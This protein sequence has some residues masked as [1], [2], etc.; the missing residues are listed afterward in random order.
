MRALG[1]FGVAL[2]AP[3]FVWLAIGWLPFVPSVV[4]VFGVHGLRW[5]AAVT[6]FGLLVAAIGFWDY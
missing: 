4:D 6:V 5:P 1:L 2:A 3:L